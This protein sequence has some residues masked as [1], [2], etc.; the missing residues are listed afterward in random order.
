MDVIGTVARLQVQRS[1][2][3]P[4]PR[5]AR[6]YDPAPLLEVSCLDVGPRGVTGDGH[7]DVHHAD[8]P[9]SRNV[10]LL[11]GLSLLPRAH[12]ERLRARFGP[13]LVD[14][15]AG[16]SVLLETD[17]PWTAEDVTGELLLE[18]ADGGLLPLSGGSPAAPCVEFT[19]FCLQRPPGPD[20]EELAAALEELG[21]GTRGFYVLAGGQ[22]QVEPGAR[23]FR[24]SPSRRA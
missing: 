4:G 15:S 23:L 10:R 14:G 2:L 12:Y 19:R 18:T 22:G 1:P 13:H 6:V 7:L 21:G 3:K 17:G 5:G 20:D 11:N 16:E 24:T 9:Q 8:H